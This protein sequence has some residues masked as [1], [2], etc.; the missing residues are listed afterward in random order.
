MQSFCLRNFVDSISR[1]YT[2][3]ENN[4]PHLQHVIGQKIG[5]WTERKRNVDSEIYVI[6]LRTSLC[7]DQSQDHS[8]L[9]GVCGVGKEVRRVKENDVMSWR[10]QAS[11]GS[12]AMYQ[13][14]PNLQP[15]G[16]ECVFKA[17]A[18]LFSRPIH[19]RPK[20]WPK[21]VFLWGKCIGQSL[22]VNRRMIEV[23]HH[24]GWRK[25]WRRA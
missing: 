2:F 25:L 11:C 3:K 5:Q 10:Q 13:E 4:L 6:L 18:T 21:G 24:V 17:H 7:V 22:D 8:T 23:F 12:C 20:G 15:F 9:Q 14:S 19:Q 1:E 16:T